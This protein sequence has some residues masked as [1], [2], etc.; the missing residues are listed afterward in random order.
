[1]IDDNIR[2]AYQN[3]EFAFMNLDLENKRKE[4]LNK[5][6]DITEVFEKI[7]ETENNEKL[8]YSYTNEEEYLVYLNRLIYKLENEL[9][10][11]L[12]K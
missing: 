2:I 6:N 11:M 12:N 5:L 8:E 10:K 9:G 3:L 1:M 4:I 7:N